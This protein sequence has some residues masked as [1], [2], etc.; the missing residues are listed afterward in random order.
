MPPLF[1]RIFA[2]DVHDFDGMT[3]DDDDVPFTPAEN[4]DLLQ[5]QIKFI[6]RYEQSKN[7]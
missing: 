7:Y 1:T 2:R 4:C 5:S 3:G 6:M